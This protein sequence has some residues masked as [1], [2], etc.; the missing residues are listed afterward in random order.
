[1]VAV[2]PG[3]V[4]TR[5]LIIVLLRLI[6]RLQVLNSKQLLF[7]LCFI[8]PEKLHWLNNPGFEHIR[9]IL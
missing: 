1:M 5:I 9:R 2:C 4:K 3:C 7:S 8:E 6:L